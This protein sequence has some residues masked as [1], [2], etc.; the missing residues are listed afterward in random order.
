MDRSPTRDPGVWQRPLTMILVGFVFAL[1]LWWMGLPIAAALMAAFA[2]FMGF[3]TSPLRSG[4]H[5][6][7]QQAARRRADDVAIVL[8]AP[9]DALSSRLHTAIRGRRDDV[10]WVNVDQD[11]QAAQ[12][13]AEVG[14]RTKL[15]LA[16]VGQDV[17]TEVTVAELLDMRA[18]GAERA[19][20]QRAPRT[21][22][23]DTSD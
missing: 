14:G 9:G 6:P 2:L 16:I 13:L 8:W 19:A 15:P 20:A 7:L 17:R 21:S 10:I 4:P 23:D 18:A 12:M 22:T 11:P 3:W 1:L 5:V